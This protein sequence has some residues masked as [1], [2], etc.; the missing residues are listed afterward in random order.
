MKKQQCIFG[1]PGNSVYVTFHLLWCCFTWQ[2]DMDIWMRSTRKLQS[3]FACPLDAS[4]PEFHRAT[5]TWTGHSYEAESTG[6][7]ASSR[8]WGKV[9]LKPSLL[10]LKVAAMPMDL[11]L[12]PPLSCCSGNIPQWRH[13]TLSVPKRDAKLTELFKPFECPYRLFI[14]STLFLLVVKTKE[15][16]LAIDVE[17]TQQWFQSGPRTKTLC[18]A[19]PLSHPR[20]GNRTWW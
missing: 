18:A 20:L 1:L 14:D 6:K 3:N 9:P 5:I 8:L 10:C 7:Q 4:R 19:F 16:W 13:V 15:C 11:C 17:K 12:P 2:T